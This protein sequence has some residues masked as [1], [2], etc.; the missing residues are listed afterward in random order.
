MK[1]KI[2]KIGGRWQWECREGDTIIYGSRAT[3][4]EALEV[5]LEQIKSNHKWHSIEELRAWKDK[6]SV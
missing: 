5:A 4:P 2:R 6:W 1:A 3:Q